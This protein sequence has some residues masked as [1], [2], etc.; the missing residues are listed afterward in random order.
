MGDGNVA[1]HSEMDRVVCLLEELRRLVTYSLARTPA[2]VIVARKDMDP[3]L[4][5]DA[6]KKAYSADVSGRDIER[7]LKRC[8]DAEDV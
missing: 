3:T 5:A 6:V 1:E 7:L 4:V 2:I 8:L